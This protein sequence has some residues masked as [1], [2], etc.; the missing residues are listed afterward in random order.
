[1]TDLTSADHADNPDGV[2]LRGDDEN[3]PKLE[4]PVAEPGAQGARGEIQRLPTPPHV[5]PEVR[6]LRE[7]R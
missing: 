4:M 7:E 6:R 2:S 5:H 3:H 1:M